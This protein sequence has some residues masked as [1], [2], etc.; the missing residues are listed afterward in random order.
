MQEVVNLLERYRGREEIVLRP[1]EVPPNSHDKLHAL[2]EKSGY[3][4]LVNEG[5]D[6]R[7]STRRRQV[8]S[9][10]PDRVAACLVTQ[11]HKFNAALSA[12]L[13]AAAKRTYWLQGF[14]ISARSREVC[15]AGKEVQPSAWFQKGGALVELHI[16]HGL[17]HLLLRMSMG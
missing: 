13:A 11:L 4:R 8:A 7:L 10:C 1:H 9:P 12:L 15:K 2:V 3:Y 6:S 5:Y 14:S 17:W 16:A